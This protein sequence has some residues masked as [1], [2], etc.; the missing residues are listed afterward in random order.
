MIR[1]SAASLFDHGRQIDRR[2]AMK[3]FRET[4]IDAKT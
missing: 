3:K 4:A 1:R 2:H